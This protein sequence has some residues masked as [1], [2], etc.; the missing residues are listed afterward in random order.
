MSS[1]TTG[2][3]AGLLLALVGAVGGFGW[4]LLAVLLGAVGYAVG[5]HLEG[6]VD[7]ASV[8]PGRRG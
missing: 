8:L 4:L 6:R 5:A 7:L 3:L 2:L 1:S